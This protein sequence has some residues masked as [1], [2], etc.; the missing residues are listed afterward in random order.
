M[1]YIKQ[2]MEVCLHNT[3]ICKMIDCNIRM[4]ELGVIV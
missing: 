3:H 2:N 1:K 4:V